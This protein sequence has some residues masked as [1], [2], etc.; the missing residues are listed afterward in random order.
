MR[1]KR[2]FFSMLIILCIVLI[3]GCK[4]DDDSSTTTPTP[5]PAKSYLNLTFSPTNAY[6]ATDGSMTSPV[7]SNQAKL[8]S[9]KIDITYID[10]NVENKPIFYDPKKRSQLSSASWYYLSWTSNAV[11]TRYYKT[12]LTKADFEAATTDQSK[13]ATYFSYTTTVLAGSDNPGICIGTP[14]EIS[15]SEGQVWGFIN[16]ASGKR[17]LIYMRTDQSQG[18]PI[19]FYNF[20]TK[21]DIIREN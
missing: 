20:N 18:W 9:N 8:V 16:T 17:G 12:A 2:Q 7:D 21:V 15:L 5:T 6:F 1:T 10:D 19:P 3:S 13:I 4:K 14:G 11:E